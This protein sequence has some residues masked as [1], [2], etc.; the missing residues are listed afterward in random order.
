MTGNKVDFFIAGVQKGGT[1]A[2]DAVL[3][4]HPQIQM[5]SVKEVHFFDNETLNWVEPDITK[6]HEHF[7][8][9]IPNVLRGEATP[10]YTYWES[11]LQRLRRYNPNAR[12]ITGL[13]H[14]IFRAYSH[15]RMEITRGDEHLDFDAAITKGRERIP[16]ESQHRVFSYVERGFYLAQIRRVLALFPR[17]NVHFFRTDMLWKQPGVELARV[18]NFLGVQA[19]L[20]PQQEYIVP[21][22][23]DS[24]PP[25]HKGAY[26]SLARI[27]DST[28]SEL[29][30]L[31]GLDFEDWR[32][33][34]Y[35][36]P[37][38]NL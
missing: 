5:A 13:R 38:Q 7:D 36:E 30:N 26:E 2:L 18:Q 28:I 11:A 25:M 27:F 14:P 34:D 29:G 32:D 17:S 12:I 31:T 19:L 15:W 22:R 33:P 9:S 16:K 10:I 21:M 4:R 20:S 1:T 37:M 6:L 23:S 8:W 3:R 35:S 24:Q